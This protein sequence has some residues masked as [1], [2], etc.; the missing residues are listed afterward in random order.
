RALYSASTFAASSLRRLAS[1]SSALMRWAR[2]SSAVSTVRWTPIQAKA[3]TRMM[4]AIATQVSGSWNNIELSL[5]GRVD[6]ASHRFAIGSRAGE[7]LHDGAGRI[8]GNATDVAHRARAGGGDGLLGLGELGRELVFQ[9]L[10]FRFRGSI[11]LF[12]VGCAD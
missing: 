8:R 4:N 9:R 6:G 5:Q 7:P 3:I 1:S 12:A 2:W 11:Q 10:A